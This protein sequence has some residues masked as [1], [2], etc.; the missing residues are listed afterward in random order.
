[1]RKSFHLLD[2]EV[3]SN[4]AADFESLPLGRQG[5]PKAWKS[6]EVPRYRQLF[7]ELWVCRQFP[8]VQGAFLAELV[9]VQSITMKAFQKRKTRWLGL[10]VPDIKKGRLIRFNCDALSSSLADH[11]SVGSKLDRKVDHG[12]VQGVCLAWSEVVEARWSLHLLDVENEATTY[13][14]IAK[15]LPKL[16]C[17]FSMQRPVAWFGTVTLHKIIDH[18]FLRS[19]AWIINLCE[20]EEEVQ[21]FLMAST[22]GNLWLSDLLLMGWQCALNGFQ[23]TIL[24]VYR[25]SHKENFTALQ[26]LWMSW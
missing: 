6:I 19:W 2:L 12:V 14:T 11:L 17:V 16:H 13:S 22:R 7:V 23:R 1:M 18:L 9:K 15:A 10:T 3:F 21:V 25:M 24:I 5:W 8:V 26:R 4:F 20:G